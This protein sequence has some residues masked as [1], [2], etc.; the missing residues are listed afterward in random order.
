M[1]QMFH[2]LPVGQTEDEDMKETGDFAYSVAR[3]A[4]LA[5]LVQKQVEITLTNNPSLQLMRQA[6]SSVTAT[7]CQEP[8]TK[9]CKMS[10]GS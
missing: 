1:Q 8:F 7:D 4:V 10:C 3:E 5:A 9:Q 2:R 6:L